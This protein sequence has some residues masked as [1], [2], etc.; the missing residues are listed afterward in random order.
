MPSLGRTITFLIVVALAACAS[1]LP[2]DPVDPQ[3]LIRLRASAEARQ[4]AE[5]RQFVEQLLGRIKAEHDAYVSKRSSRPPSLDILIISGGGD[6]GAFGASFLK[7]WGKVPASHPLARP[8]FDIVT[9]V[10]TGALIAPFAFIGTDDA[11]DNVISL[12]RKPAPDLVKARGWFF[13]QPNNPSFAEVPGLEREMR[14]HLTPEMLKRI[15]T[16]G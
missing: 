6:W 16:A 3:Q 1:E 2:R 11:L 8:Q 12:Y 10:S 15:V 4:A 7:G 5:T 13:F 14:T 9:G